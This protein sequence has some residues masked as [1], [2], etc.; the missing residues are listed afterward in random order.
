LVRF[1]W[2]ERYA[3]DVITAWVECSNDLSTV[4]EQ[5]T[6][7]VWWIGQAQTPFLGDD[8]FTALLV[9]TVP[10]LK[11]RLFGFEVATAIIP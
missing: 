4:M 6:Q 9:L 5:A 1:L 8:C 2:A 10:D 3:F 11:N 7:P